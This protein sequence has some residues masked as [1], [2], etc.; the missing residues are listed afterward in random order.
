MAATTIWLIEIPI[1]AANQLADGDFLLETGDNLILEDSSGN[2]DL[3]GLLVNPLRDS[4][5]SQLLI[6]CTLT[7]GLGV[8]VD[9]FRRYL[10]DKG[11]VS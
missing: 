3:E 7:V 9:Y 11:A 5:K 1:V 10:N 6:G 8:P 4:D 2:L